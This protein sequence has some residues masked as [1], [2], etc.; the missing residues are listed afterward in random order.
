MHKTYIK[1]KL[2]CWVWVLFWYIMMWYSAEQMLWF[3]PSMSLTGW[4]AS[5]P[6]TSPYSKRAVHLI[7]DSDSVSK[8][9]HLFKQGWI[10]TPLQPKWHIELA[11]ERQDSNKNSE[12]WCMIVIMVLLLPLL[13]LIIII[14]IANWQLKQLYILAAQHSFIALKKKACTF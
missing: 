13:P 1:S 3:P 7:P 11:Q 2:M 8:S 10:F 14:I 5:P 6:T 12:M 4:E 9:V